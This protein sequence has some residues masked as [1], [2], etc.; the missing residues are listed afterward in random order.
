MMSERRGRARADLWSP[1][2]P[3]VVQNLGLNPYDVRKKCDKAEDKDG[4]LCYKQMGY[5]EKWMNRPEIK[6]EL[7]G[8]IPSSLSLPRAISPLSLEFPFPVPNWIVPTEREFKSCNMDVN[9]AFM[10]VRLY[11]L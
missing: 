4:P 11:S 7:G 1:P 8:E 3:I 6:A 10:M 5:V 2:I 9:K